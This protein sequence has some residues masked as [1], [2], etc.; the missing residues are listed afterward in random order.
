MSSTNYRA[1]KVN[2]ITSSVQL[3]QYSQYPTAW[4][5]MKGESNPT[6]SVQLEG[7]GSVAFASLDNH[8]IFPCYPASITMTTGSIMLL[9]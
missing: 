5:I 4:A 3:G 2:I 7:G 6:G 9:Q 8:Q 1:Y